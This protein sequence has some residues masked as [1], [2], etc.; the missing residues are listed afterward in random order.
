MS[1]APVSNQPPYTRDFLIQYRQ[2][3]INQ[4]NALALSNFVTTVTNHVL[5]AAQQGKVSFTVTQ[6]PVTSPIQQAIDALKVNFPDIAIRPVNIPTGQ[7][8]QSAPGI[9]ISWA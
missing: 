6:I 9:L 3:Y 7:K 1:S 5:A 2:A 8:L 4:Q